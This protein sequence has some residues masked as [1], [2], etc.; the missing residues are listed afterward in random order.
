MPF[1]K[2]NTKGTVNEIYSSNPFV[3]TSG[4]GLQC[5]ASYDHGCTNRCTNW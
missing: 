5:R 3:Y 4:I 1:F 2:P